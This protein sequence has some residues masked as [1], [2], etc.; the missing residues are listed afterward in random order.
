MYHSNIEN[1][2]GPAFI[3]NDD[4][5]C[6]C[7]SRSL[8]LLADRRLEFRVYFLFVYPI[9]SDMEESL[10]PYEME[11]TINVQILDDA[12]LVHANALGKDT[13]PFVP[14]LAMGN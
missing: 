7:W 2:E 6:S 4:H 5:E 11:S 12:M 10:T 9:A 3:V 8:I 13:N 1:P 14:L